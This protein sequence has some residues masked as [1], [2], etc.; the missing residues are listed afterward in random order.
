[1]NELDTSLTYLK[2][3]GPQRADLLSSELGLRTFGDLLEYF[4][5][6]YV[7]RSKIYNINEIA[8]GLSE[9]QVRG[10]LGDI[11]LIGNG[12]KKRR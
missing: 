7:D 6:R 11:R 4:P 5:F 8:P 9:I 10:S 3:V 1:M 12:Y 2:G